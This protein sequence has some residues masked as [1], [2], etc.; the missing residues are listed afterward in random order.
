VSGRGLRQGSRD[1]H[2]DTG[3]LA[4][5]TFVMVYVRPLPKNREK[6]QT[7]SDAAIAVGKNHHR[8][9]SATYYRC[10]THKKLAQSSLAV[11]QY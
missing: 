7:V 5:Q 2:K 4:R 1:Q 9:P 11:A 8:E 10:S 6:T 3:L